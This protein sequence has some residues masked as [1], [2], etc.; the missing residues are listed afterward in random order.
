MFTQQ[1]SFLILLLLM[2][3]LIVVSTALTPQ[4]RRSKWGLLVAIATV[5]ALSGGFLLLQATTKNPFWNAVDAGDS[6]EVKRLISQHPDL[7]EART[8]MG[9]TALH[10]AV[11]SANT[12][13]VEILLNAG[14]NVNAQ[15]EAKITSLHIAA[16][17]GN[18][19]IAELLLKAGANVN[20]IGYRHNNTPLHVA[21]AHGHLEV[22]R[23]L[24]SHGADV[25][26]VD[27]LNKTAQQVAEENGYT[28]IVAEMAGYGAPNSTNQI[29][30]TK[31]LTP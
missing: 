15:A 18:A 6:E 27:M 19:S 24:I 9:Y 17:D 11:K 3:V 31:H 25:D 1:F 8:F 7:I 28:N 23:I 10:R 4:W 12:N 22:V 5:S 30:G 21:A 20:A 26:V 2:A 29:P 14:A 16:F 13:L